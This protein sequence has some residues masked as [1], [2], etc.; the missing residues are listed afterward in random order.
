MGHVDYLFGEAI[1]QQQPAY[2]HAAEITTVAICANAR[3]VRNLLRRLKK[4]DTEN[5]HID[6]R[7]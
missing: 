1:G 3:I 7:V 5:A 2:A 4:E 6:D